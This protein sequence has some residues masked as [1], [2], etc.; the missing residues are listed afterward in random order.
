MNREIYGKSFG[1]LLSCYWHVR[2]YCI[3]KNIDFDFSNFTKTGREEHCAIKSIS[4][5][6]FSCF[7]FKIKNY[8]LENNVQENLEITDDYVRKHVG[9]KDK[10]NINKFTENYNNRLFLYWSHLCIGS[11]THII[12]TI[13]DDTSKN[14]KEYLD[15][16]QFFFPKYSKNEVVIHFRC[17]NVLSGDTHPSYHLLKF[18]YF[19]EHI[20]EKTDKITIIWRISYDD[21]NTKKE[22]G[23]LS[24]DEFIINSLKQYLEKE[25]NIEVNIDNEYFSD[26]IYLVYAPT[27]IITPSTFSFWAGVMSRN[28]CYAPSC[29]LLCGGK[30]TYLRD[31]FIWTDIEPYKISAHFTWKMKHN[32]EKL[33]EELLK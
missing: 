19:K 30:N 33:L 17:G 5:N 22:T 13:Q 26:F 11:W 8:N 23:I 3:Y 31:N 7:P 27:L 28:T 6:L 9:C 4:G 25:L 1:N 10:I 2:A 24:K 29:E 20:P 18:K 32:N 16:K 12:P 15:I 21:K 14:I